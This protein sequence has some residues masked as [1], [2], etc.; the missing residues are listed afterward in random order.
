MEGQAASPD[1]L[2]SFYKRMIRLRGA[3][4][5]LA[6]GSA[7]SV[8]AEGT[9]SNPLALLRQAEGRTVLAVYNLSAKANDVTVPAAAIPAATAWKDLFGGTGVARASTSDPLALGTLD[10]WSFRLLEAAP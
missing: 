3:T 2:L 4:P 10:P 6:V 9:V 1:S 8:A 5:P 7:E